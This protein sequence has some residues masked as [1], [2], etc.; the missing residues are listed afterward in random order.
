[1]KI[2][3]A[4]G[5]GFLGQP[6]VEHFATR[7]FDVVVL[8]RSSRP[9]S[10]DPHVREVEWNPSDT[11]DVASLGPWAR[12]I[13]GANVVI[14]L[15]GAGLAARRWTDRY[16]QELRRSRV[17]S[18]RTLVAAVRVA[19]RRPEVFVQGSAVGFYGTDGDQTFDESYPPG[20]DFLGQMCVAWEAEAH[21]ISAMGPRL[22]V[23]RTGI[24]LERDG[25]A[26]K[27]MAVPFLFFVGGPLGSGRQYVSWIHR[28]DWIAIVD[29]AVEKQ[30]LAGPLNATAEVPV[31]NAHLAKAIGQA[32][33]RPSWLPVPGLALTAIVG[34]MAGVALLRGQRVVPAVARKLGFVFRYPEIEPALRA[35]YGRRV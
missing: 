15:A 12:E 22:V 7:K 19:T 18:T 2:V 13:D 33:H 28:D 3:I 30:E 16:K 9:P 1:M 6:L 24:V 26:L 29:W 23:L 17:A 10:A 25:G 20:D 5:S 21:P 34:E 32:I 8:T 27:Q 14:N 11:P 31:T 4:G 35:I